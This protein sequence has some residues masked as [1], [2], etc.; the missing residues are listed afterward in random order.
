[1]GAWEQGAVKTALITGG[2]SGLG[3]VH[4][5]RLADEGY[6]VAILDV[7]EAGLRETA[8]QSPR[9]H[10]YACD[11]TD[12]AKVQQT[13]ST[14][15]EAHGPVDRLIN[16]AAIMPGGLL[17]DHS[18]EQ[19]SR[20]MEINYVGMVNVCQTVVPAMV[21]RDEGEVILYGSTAGVMPMQRFGA[22]GA[23]KAAN[24]FYARLLIAENRSKVRMTL[25]FPPSVNTPLLDQAADGPPILNTR[26]GRR[27]LTVEPEGVVAAA[28]RAV[29]RGRKSCLPGILPRI[30]VMASWFA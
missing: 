14:V 11:V 15:I 19:I 20:I 9:I 1:M 25:V 18:A 12:L 29:R 17:L 16:C 13:V 5:L 30:I 7:N 23:S 21:A 24:N 27:F 4:A 26:F 6:A 22:Y 3:R 8:S 2:A 28:E 10:R